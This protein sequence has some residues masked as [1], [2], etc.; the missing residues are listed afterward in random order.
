ME[1]VSENLRGL[2][3]H[4]D[5]DVQTKSRGSP[6]RFSETASM[7]PYPLAPLS[8]GSAGEVEDRGSEKSEK[9]VP[10]IGLAW[11]GNS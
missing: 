1:A 11:C 2:P 6:L 7:R 10:R 4:S 3:P 8:V 5:V 9:Q